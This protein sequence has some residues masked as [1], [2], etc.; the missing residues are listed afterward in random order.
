MWELT[1]EGKNPSHL[2]AC[3]DPLVKQRLRR[4]L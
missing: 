1:G 2:F 3:A 4:T